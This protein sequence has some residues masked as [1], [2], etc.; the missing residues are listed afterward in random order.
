MSQQQMQYIDSLDMKF[1]E[2]LENQ[3]YEQAEMYRSLRDS[4]IRDSQSACE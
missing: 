3:K 1:E 2:S 4:A